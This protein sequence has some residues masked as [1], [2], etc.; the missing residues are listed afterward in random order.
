MATA[1]V[2][3]KGKAKASSFHGIPI[4][5]IAVGG[6]AGAYLLYRWYKSRSASTSAASTDT[7]TTAT[8]TGTGSTDSGYGAGSGGGGDN[9]GQP[10]WTNPTNY[11]GTTGTTTGSDTTTTPDTTPYT[12]PTPTPN[13]SSQPDT[14]VTSLS[15]STRTISA[16][17]K[18]LAQAGTA[19]RANPSPSTLAALNKAASNVNLTSSEVNKTEASVGASAAAQRNLG[20]GKA[21]TSTTKAAAKPIPV[22]VKKAI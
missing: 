20:T 4:W 15:P 3:P 16:A 1:P 7:G 9:S 19:Y 21:A 13:P 11:S 2:V 6:A 14:T 5:V 18:V 10:W 8:D 12:T 17:E 22:Q